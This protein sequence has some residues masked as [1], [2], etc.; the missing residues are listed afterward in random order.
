M[1]E[2]ADKGELENSKLRKHKQSTRK[3]SGA[4]SQW[5]TSATNLHSTTLRT[6][7]RIELWILR[8]RVSCFCPEMASNLW[9][10]LAMKKNLNV[11][12]IKTP[13]YGNC[14]KNYLKKEKTSWGVSGFFDILIVYRDI[15]T[16]GQKVSRKKYQHFPTHFGLPLSLECSGEISRQ[17]VKST[18]PIFSPKLKWEIL[19]CKVLS[20]TRAMSGDY[21]AL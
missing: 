14:L 15:S 16:S 18:Y 2:T 11:R 13:Y 1:K 19:A 10:V 21:H 9:N 17:S 12:E 5:P 4:N 3:N 8:W 20:T 7:Y 6:K